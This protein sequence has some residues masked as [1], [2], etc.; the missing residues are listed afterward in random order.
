M[1]SAGGFEVWA[2]S[3]GSISSLRNTVPLPNRD[4]EF[5]ITTTYE[6]QETVVG[7]TDL[8]FYRSI[9]SDVSL[10]SAR[11]GGSIYILAAAQVYPFLQGGTCNRRKC[12][13]RVLPFS[14]EF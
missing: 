4:M 5:V 6:I 3:G 7:S 2:I 1:E 13:F 9:A 14:G 12:Y 10:G 11:L 8:C